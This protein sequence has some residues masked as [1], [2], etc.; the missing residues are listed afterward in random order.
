MVS[1]AVA[2]A[3]I[4][5]R[6]MAQPNDDDDAELKLLGRTLAYLRREAGLTQAQVAE[7]LDTSTQNYGKYENAK[8]PTLYRQDV[9]RNLAAALGVDLETFL[10]VRARLAGQTVQSLNYDRVFERASDTFAHLR[11]PRLVIRHRLQAAWTL[12]D[13]DMNYG[14][15][16]MGRDPRW[17]NADQ[18]LDEM[19]DDHAEGLGINRGDLVHCVSAADTGYFP[20]EGELV[21]VARSRPVE[22]REITLRQVEN[23]ASKTLLHARTSNPRLR[24][25]L[26]L[27][28][29]TTDPDA[30]R[31]LAFATASV[32]R[33]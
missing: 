9:Q 8:A 19:S 17:E 1:L 16:H 22:E 18:W 33:Y 20:R 4:Q 28:G 24:A 7:R 29:L 12:D 2:R 15:W 13:D 14:N 25:P 27:A 26:E 31:I 21:I 5:P 30:P 23:T 10:M 11:P 6:W 3:P 32:K